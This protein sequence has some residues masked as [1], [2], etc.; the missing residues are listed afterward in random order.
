MR[1]TIDIN[2][3]GIEVN[4]ELI[5]ALKNFK[6]SSILD[7]NYLRIDCVITKEMTEHFTDTDIKEITKRQMAQELSSKLL[8]KYKD[9]VEETEAFSGKRLSLSILAMS[10]TELKHI[11]EYCIRTMP[12]SSIVEIRK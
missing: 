4:S 1:S 9:S 10:K 11:V 3:D 7:S 12:E 6:Q 2:I 8:E 5:K